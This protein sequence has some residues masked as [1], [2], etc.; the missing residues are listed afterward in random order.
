M[1]EKKSLNTSNMKSKK[2]DK[3]FSDAIIIA[4]IGAVAV[5]LAALIGIVP[6]LF[7]PTIESATRVVTISP[8]LV[9]TELSALTPFPTLP[10]AYDPHPYTDDYHDA[11][12]VPMR[13]VS[14][15]EF[16]MGDTATLALEECQRFYG[17]ECN[18]VFFTNAEPRHKVDLSA[19]YIDKYEVTN[20]LYAS[21]VN[22]GVCE[23][24]TKTDSATRTS[25]YGN[26]EFD[27]YPVIYVD[28]SMAKEYCG[29]RGARLPTEAEWEKAAR[30]TDGRY[31]PW[32]DD[33]IDCNHANITFALKPEGC[34]GDTRRVGSYEIGRSPYN[35]YDMSGNVWEWVADWYS[36]TYYKISPVFN[37]LGPNTGENHVL[38]GGS[39]NYYGSMFLGRSTTRFW[40]D[41]A[42]FSYDNSVG[43]RCA[44]SA[45]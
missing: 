24:P 9:S 1:A 29:W 40:D 11:F 43:I 33:V 15:G 18:L 14:A 5:I 36:E 27:N 31:Y 8:S 21:C 30:G 37:P 23:P 41:P 3:K 22:A 45:P 17:N 26:S 20:A 25:Y 19:F 32:G 28:W 2:R 4:L 44:H 6:Q 35:I 39:W 38:R 34:V 7:K 12:G 10:P 13:L 16:T 42:T